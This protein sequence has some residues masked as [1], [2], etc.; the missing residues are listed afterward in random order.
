MV[1]CVDV[2]AGV[3]GGTRLMIKVIFYNFGEKVIQRY[4]LKSA[5][6]NMRRQH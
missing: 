1:T 3:F 5:R 2:D 4:D 6:R